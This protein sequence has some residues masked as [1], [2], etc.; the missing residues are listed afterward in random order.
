MAPVPI[1]EARIMDANDIQS[2]PGQLEGRVIAQ[3]LL[4][5]AWQQRPLRPENGSKMGECSRKSR[6]VR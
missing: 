3:V 1:A 6:V 5:G 4:S 2:P